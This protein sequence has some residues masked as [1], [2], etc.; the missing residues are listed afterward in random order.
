[1]PNSRRFQQPD[2]KGTMVSLAV[3]VNMH[4]Q[5]PHTERIGSRHH[6]SATRGPPLPRGQGTSALELKKSVL[7]QGAQESLRVVAGVVEVLVGRV[8]GVVRRAAAVLV[9]DEHGIAKRGP[10][11]VPVVLPAAGWPGNHADDGR[12]RFS[13]FVVDEVETLADE[14]PIILK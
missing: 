5:H 11:R 6:P 13:L 9:G 4:R 2:G 10:A 3:P 12:L 8:G 1:M 7:R 14:G